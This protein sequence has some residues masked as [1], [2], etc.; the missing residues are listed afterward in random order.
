MARAMC[1]AGQQWHQEMFSMQ[2]VGFV[3][4]YS[5]C[6]IRTRLVLVAGVFEK[7]MLDCASV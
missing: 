1:R 6:G 2:G 5:F 4:G 7:V 3:D